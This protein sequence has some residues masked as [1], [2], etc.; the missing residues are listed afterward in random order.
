MKI[1]FIILINFYFSKCQ[2][3]CYKI[4]NFYTD[5][6][7]TF[8]RVIFSHVPIQTV[9]LFEIELYAPVSLSNVSISYKIVRIFN[10]FCLIIGQYRRHQPS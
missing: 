5:N 9:T 10:K 7:G 2:Q 4:I 3:S 8:G 6:F 1:I